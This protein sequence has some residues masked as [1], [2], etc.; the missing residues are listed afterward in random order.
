MKTMMRCLVVV[1]FVGTISI[2][3]KAQWV[4]AGLKSMKVTSLAVSSTNLFAGTD[5]NGVYLSTNNGLEWSAVGLTN[6]YVCSLEFID[7]I[8]FAGTSS[9][10]FQS[11]NSGSNWTLINS[12]LP[13]YCV[14]NSFIKIGTNLFAGSHTNGVFIST[15]NGLTWS[16]AT[17]DMLHTTVFSL[18]VSPTGTIFAGTFGGIFYSTNNGTNWTQVMG[19][20]DG[21]SNPTINCLAFTNKGY[22]FAGSRGS[23]NFGHFHGWV[24]RSI[25]NGL[26]WTY[27]NF[28]ILGRDYFSLINYGNYLIAGT[29]SGVYLSN[30]NC[31]SWTAANTGLSSLFIRGLKVSDANLIA[32]TDSGIYRRPLS[33]MITDVKQSSSP[34]PEKYS[35]S[36]NYP[37]PFNPSTTITYSIPERSTVRL[38]IFNTLGQKISEVVNETK[39][40]GS[41]EHNFNASQLSSGIYFYRIEATSTQN[42]GK[43]L[44][45]T[46]KM[47]LM[48]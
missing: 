19:S 23:F 3:L 43:T 47:V 30:N 25:N 9:G 8:L 5:S 41:Y 39:D 4:T 13:T 36:Q 7:S 28:G 48:K 12:G 32:S 37:N 27:D 42:A 18:T 14:V 15:N 16:N 31:E 35:L 46:K 26:N 40:A 2:Q 45:D 33:E 21:V 11:T 34:T 24:R 22:C 29:D 1:L 44:V 6:N 17:G 38:S 10:V 20:L